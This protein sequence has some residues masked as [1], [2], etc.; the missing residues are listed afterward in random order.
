MSKKILVT[1]LCTLHWGRLQYGNV[2]NYYIMEPMF[3][4]LHERFPEHE[5]ATTFQMD[6]RFV[7][8]EKVT[9]LPMELYYAW[10][11]DDVANAKKDVEA[12]TA[13][14]TVANETAYLAA[15]K[16]CDLIINVSGD[17]WGDN[18]EHVG[19]DRFLVDCLKMRAA[20]LLGKKTILYAVTPGAFE[21]VDKALAKEVFESFDLVLIRERV[22]FGNLTKWGFDISRVHYIPCPSYLFEPNVKYTSGWSDTINKKKEAG[23]RVVGFTFGGF[24]MPVGPYDMWPRE[25]SQYDTFKKAVLKLV[26]EHDADVVLFSHTN[27]FLLPPKFKLINGRDFQI[28]SRFYEILL[29]TNPEI[30][31]RILLINEPLLPC[32]LKHVIGLFDMLVTGR[33][34]ASVASTSQCVPTV[35][36]EYDRRVI[37][38]DKMTGFSAQVGM[39]RYVCNPADEGELLSKIEDCIDNL[40]FIRSK[41]GELVP[42]VQANAREGFNMMWKVYSEGRILSFLKDVD[43]LFTPTLS[44]RVDLNAYAKKLATYANTIFITNACGDEDVASCSFYADKEIAYVSSIAVKQEYHHMGYGMQLM[45]KVIEICRGK[46]CSCIRLEAYTANDASVRYYKRMGFS[47]LRQNEQIIEFEYNL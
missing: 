4:L 43:G 19:H 34:H 20:Q 2:G 17:M 38:S 12:A 24:N 22:S 16:D 27:G 7:K 45:D 31:D 42:T 21:H 9:V 47:V 44:A 29:A 26:C 41:L 6:D 8:Q 40:D 15:I 13:G 30:A 36:V 33:V 35:F 3:R 23:R 32:D 1:G 11:D 10:K 14:V 18:A 39:E 25:E 37:Y 46:G 28:L 5:I